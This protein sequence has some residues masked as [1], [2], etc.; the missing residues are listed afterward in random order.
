MQTEMMDASSY[1]LSNFWSQGDSLSHAVVLVLLIM[2]ILSWTQIAVKAW[3]VWHRNSITKAVENF[4]RETTLTKAAKNFNEELGASH[5]FSELLASAVN[6]SHH[7]DNHK[8]NEIG[9]N[10]DRE[11]FITRALRQTINRA[12]AKLES[13]M[14]ILA[15]IGAVSPFVGLFGTVYGIYNALLGISAAGSASL[16]TVSGPVGEALIMTALGLFVA[17]PAVLA[18]NAFI[19]YN[20]LEL[21]ELDGFAH[22]LHSYFTTG[23]RLK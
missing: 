1:G 19:R 4:W 21:M 12:T 20:R 5:N 10:L 2:S 14:T 22:D 16:N 18:Y 6:A 7:F 9:K 13:G 15:S 3:R 17:I 23:G 8:N 11:E